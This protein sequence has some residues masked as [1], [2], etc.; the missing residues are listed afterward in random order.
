MN[1]VA[2]ARSTLDAW[3][4]NGDDRANPVRFHLIDALDKRA[5]AY[6]GEARRMLDARVAL[7]L[8]LYRSDIERAVSQRAAIQNDDERG[9]LAT[10]VEDIA[11]SSSAYTTSHAELLE[12]FRAVWSK[13][14]AE[15]QLRD[16]L[17]Q[18]PRNA[19]PLNSS[20][21]VHRSLS[22]MREVSPG[23]FQQFLAYADALSW[24]EAMNGPG[25]VVAKDAA[26]AKKSGRKKK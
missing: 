26:G 21:L 4:A 9:P 10:L 12:Y 11:K 23:Y 18:V 22:L 13:V 8:D 3:R 17:A 7:L 5:A 25:V 2:P 14:S 20:S 1:N 19:G 6:D 16:S 15:K 24:I